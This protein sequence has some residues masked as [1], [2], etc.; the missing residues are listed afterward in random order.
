MSV[1]GSLAPAAPGVHAGG[2]AGGGGFL[3]PCL[4]VKGSFS[5][6]ARGSLGSDFLCNL[7]KAHSATCHPDTRHRED[8]SAWFAEE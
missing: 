4:W 5:R 7:G 2:G 8:Q 3:P 1:T 6:V